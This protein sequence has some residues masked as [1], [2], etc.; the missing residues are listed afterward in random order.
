MK[1]IIFPRN[2]E[3]YAIDLM[4]NFPGLVI[5]GARQTGKTTLSKTI[6]PQ[7]SY[8]DLEKPS[9]QDRI[10][11][12]PEFFFSQY[13]QRLIL[14][15]AQEMPV[16]FNILRGVIDE[17]RQQNNRF[18]ITGSSS[19]E[20]M[21]K[22]SETLAGRIA[23]IELGTLKFNEFYRRSMSPFY[24][25]FKEKLSIHNLV[26][27]PA[28]F[29]R[30]QVQD[31]WLRGGYPEPVSKLKG[32]ENYFE[33]WMTNYQSTYINRDIAKLFPKLNKINFRRFLSMLGKLS[34]TILNK[35]DLAR[36]LAVSEPTIAL[37]L[38]IAN[39]TFLWRQLPSFE[40][41]I[42]KSVVKMPKG[43]IRDSGLLHHLLHIDDIETLYSDP[44]VGHSFEGFIIEEL[45]KGIQDA[46]VS[47]I[48]PYHY[49]TRGGAEIDLILEGKFGLLPIE[50]KL[51]KTVTQKQLISL[52]KFIKDHN[53]AFGLLINQADQVEWLTPSII[54]IPA[55][56]L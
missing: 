41:N 42:V 33:R 20:L 51:G 2:I 1:S 3:N 13:P 37:Y 54:Q 15:E 43:H 17:N 6:A 44:I 31:C 5:L 49:R 7:F 53:T 27:G 23:V 32:N 29:T 10:A 14:D 4:N 19:T 47:N 55:G 38:E 46:G 28:P 22:V 12:D 48:L 56:W 40:N 50:V 18:I 34:G 45:L 25:L 24:N 26:S 30:Q 36:A 35:S 21:D 8:F 9:D 16:I 52:N 39:G 11:R